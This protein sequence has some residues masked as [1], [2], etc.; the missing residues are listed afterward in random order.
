MFVPQSCLTLSNPMDC[1]LPG[2]SVHQVSQARILEWVAIP[3]SRG[4]SQPRDRTGVSCIAGGFFTV[5]A[6]REVQESLLHITL[7]TGSRRNQ[8][9]DLFLILLEKQSVRTVLWKSSLKQYCDFKV[10]NPW[11][12]KGCHHAKLLGNRLSCYTSEGLLRLWGFP[13]IFK[14]CAPPSHRDTMWLITPKGNRPFFFFFILPCCVACGTLFP[15]QGSNPG[16]LQW[17]HG[18]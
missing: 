18:V 16:P 7:Y 2:S 11:L 17:K 6:T 5:W 8:L 13:S 3:F 4:S 12:S 10:V 9:L 14:D 1:S 15:D